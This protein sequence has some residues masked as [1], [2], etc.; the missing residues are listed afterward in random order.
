MIIFDCG[1]CIG[2]FFKPYIND[3]NIIHA[4]EPY[5]INFKFLENNYKNTK[6]IY[7]NNVCVGNSN[8]NIKLYRNN[9]DYNRVG[10]IG[11]SV[12]KDNVHISGNHEVHSM[13]KLSEYYTKNVNDVVDIMKLDIEGSEYDVFEDLLSA[14]LI[15]KFKTIYVEE[16][17]RCIPSLV[18]KGTT[19]MNKVKTEFKG[20]LYIWN[21]PKAFYEKVGG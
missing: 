4:F 18:E 13:I 5:A 17:V 2:E 15:N 9:T 10:Y 20:D 6:G 14:N 19:I 21:W 3:N 8:D 12:F 1:A 11:S 16:H 7:L